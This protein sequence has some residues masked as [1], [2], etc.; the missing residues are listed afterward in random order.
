MRRRFRTAWSRNVNCGPDGEIRWPLSLV[1][2]LSVTCV[3]CS[4]E[5]SGSQMAGKYKLISPQGTMVLKVNSNGRYDECVRYADGTETTASAFWGGG[6]A[7]CFTFRRIL[8]PSSVL[9]LGLLEAS[10]TKGALD[11]HKLAHD[12]YRL[13]WCMTAEGR[14]GRKFLVIDPDSEPAFESIQ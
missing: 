6:A 7:P 11:E 10:N 13:N 14:L 8:L 1:F 2:L 5:L 3:S 9:P 12:F 4:T